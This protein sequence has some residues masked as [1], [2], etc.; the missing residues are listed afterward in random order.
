LAVTHGVSTIV[1]GE[2]KGIRATRY[3]E[4]K[5]KRPECNEDCLFTAA[6]GGCQT[7]YYSGNP[8]SSPG[9]F[10]PGQDKEKISQ[11]IKIL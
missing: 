2:L 5:P 9:F 10:I 7:R 8:T 6:V 3:A 4:K 1:A 11:P